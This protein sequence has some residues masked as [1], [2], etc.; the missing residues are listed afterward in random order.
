MDIKRTGKLLVKIIFTLSVIGA[1][2]LPLITGH[3]KDHINPLSHQKVEKPNS[4]FVEAFEFSETTEFPPT[5]IL[6]SIPQFITTPEGG[7]PWDVFGET[8]E[9]EYTYEEDE[10][11]E[12]SGVR[13]EFKEK[14]KKLDG[15]TI[16]IQGYMF[17]L[18]QDEEQPIFL[19]GPFPLSCPYHYHMPPKLVLEVH[20][21]TPVTFSYDAVN[22]QGKLELVPND[23]EYNV[24]YRLKEAKILKN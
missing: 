19:L 16:I 3:Q 4:L 17:P 12:Y 21:K 9:H 22:V 6:D 24:F 10:E 8:I 20:A 23:D 1:L 18:S 14:L 2:G 7:T 11:F 13:P 5:D 15:Q